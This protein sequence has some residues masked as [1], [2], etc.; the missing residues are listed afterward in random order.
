M[1]ILFMPNLLP[2]PETLQGIPVKAVYEDTTQ[3]V[4]AEK[5]DATSWLAHTTLKAEYCE[6]SSVGVEASGQSLWLLRSNERIA[7]TNA[8]RAGPVRTACVLNGA[9][10]NKVTT[11]RRSATANASAVRATERAKLR[12]LLFDARKASTSDIIPSASN[13]VNIISTVKASDSIT[14]TVPGTG[15][16]F[17]H[18]I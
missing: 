17:S 13:A 3:T 7:I 5:A 2:A 4:R 14:M 18:I 12:V 15:S 9:C 11:I 6:I 10:L 1:S 8:A 16:F